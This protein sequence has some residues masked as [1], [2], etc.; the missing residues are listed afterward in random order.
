MLNREEKLLLNEKYGGQPNEEFLADC[1]R[2]EAGEPLAYIIGYVPFLN[3]TIWLDSHPLIPRSET[4]YWTEKASIAIKQHRAHPLQVLDLCAGSGCIGVAIAHALPET[5]VHFAELDARHLSTII[6]NL[7]INLIS[8]SRTHVFQSDLFA[9][10]SG[11]YDFILSNPPYIDPTLDRVEPSV[12]AFEPHHAL[13]GGE[14][15][16]EL[17]EHII[18]SS[19][20]FLRPQGQLWLEHEPEQETQIHE[21][22]TTHSF[23]CTTH[24]DQFS[25]PRFSILTVAQ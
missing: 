10:V 25:V 8:V 16:L 15:G 22:A 5:I 19:R 4:E 3:C 24:I 1:S 14:K 20:A 7:E 17:I 21:L 13:Y 12:R 23:N 2:L 11:Q 6:K 18:Q 9:N